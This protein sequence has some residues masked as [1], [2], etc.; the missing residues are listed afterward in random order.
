MTAQIQDGFQ[1]NIHKKFNNRFFWAFSFLLLIAGCIIISRALLLT[2]YPDF[3]NYYYG[4]VAFLHGHNPYLGLGK[5]FA[6]FAYP[7]FIFI[8]LSPLSFLSY[9]IAGKLWVAFS[10]ICFLASLYIFIGMYHHFS[11]DPVTVTA[12]AVMIATFFPA[13]FTF[14]MGQ[15]N[16]L[17]LLLIALFFLF[18]KHRED[19]LAGVVLGVAM[20]VKLFPVLFI[21]W[22][23]IRR[24]WQILIGL[25]IALTVCYGVLEVLGYARLISYY[26]I[27][28][29]PAVASGWKG[30]YYNQSLSG[31]LTR[32]VTDNGI[33]RILEIAADI[34]ILFI[35]FIPIV[36]P[37]K[38][39]Q[40]FL[41]G[42][43]I[44]VANVLVDAFSWQHHFVWIIPALIVVWFTMRELHEVR[45]NILFFASYILLAYNI[46]HPGAVNVLLRSHV[47]Y[48]GLLLWGILL[49]MFTPRCRK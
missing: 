49:W 22:L 43:L 40:F 9:V 17:I 12:L 46:A 2:S 16:M 5:V 3:T 14:G 34:G 33:R 35:T 26:Y 36:R 7:P 39:K 8:I 32:E 29:F 30:D 21:P 6:P 19:W 20:S 45:L 42:S 11:M 23:L 18:E 25:L 28:V 37:V 13:K 15:I 4:T 44:L 48:G 10:I 47:F 1:V 27:H 31:F 24:R 41:E 38:P